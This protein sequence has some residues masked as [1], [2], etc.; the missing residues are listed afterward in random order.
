VIAMPAALKKTQTVEAAPAPALD[1]RA[2]LTDAIYAEFAAK[3]AVAAK[4]A[5]VSRC[6]LNIDEAEQRLER[7]QKAIPKAKET[8]A[9]RAAAA[10]SAGRNISGASH[11]QRAEAAVEEAEHL[12]EVATAARK[13]LEADLADLK[14]DLAEASNQITVAIKELLKPL[15]RQLIDRLSDA[16]RRSAID[17]RVL[18]E[19]LADDPRATPQFVDELRESKAKKQRDAVLAEL[20]AED[21]R[22]LYGATDADHELGLQAAKAVKAALIGLRTSSA[23]PLP[24]I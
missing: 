7:A 22:P 19:L 10:L 12:L 1:D 15:A 2:G 6:R 5:A 16:R 17:M 24:K 18:S 13:K 8:D 20:K 21:A 14:D 9:A 23:T 3:N 4:E 11:T